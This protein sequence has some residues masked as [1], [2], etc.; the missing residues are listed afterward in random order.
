MKLYHLTIT[1]AM[2]AGLSLTGISISQ[3]A[4]DYGNRI[5]VKFSRGL[6]NTVTGW[7]E[8]PKDIALESK[9]RN[10]FSGITLGTVKGTFQTVGRTAVGAVELAT[11]VVPNDD[12]VHERYVWKDMDH[13]T[14]Y[15]L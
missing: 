4:D 7:V 5:G 14:T 8:L 13:E 9:E 2:L 10:I 12:I 3:A 1:I 11:F 15:G 6:A